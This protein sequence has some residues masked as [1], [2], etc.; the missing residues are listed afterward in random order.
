MRIKLKL[1]SVHSARVAINYNYSL[2]SAIYK[3]LRFGSPEFSAFLHHKGFIIKNK[4]YKLFTFSLQF[5]NAVLDGNSFIL[6]SPIAYLYV[7][8]PLVDEFIKSFVIGTFENQAIEIMAENIFTRFNIRQAEILPEPEFN[9]EM[10]FKMMTSTV[11]S[12]MKIVNGKL[13]PYYYR[14]NDD[15]NEINRVLM[16]NL[17]NK[18]SIIYNKEYSGKGIKLTWDENYINHALKNKKRL[19]KK[20]SILKDINKPIEIVGIYCPFNISGDKE[21]IKVGYECGF[22][23]KNSM[24]FGMAEVI[25]N[26]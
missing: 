12:T 25:A 26:N 24:G 16:Q 11:L 7:T 4:S 3:L 19:S 13:S 17:I 21:L 5:D 6:K 22:G 2:S 18:Y 14:Y 23:E 10:K 9:E 8:S 15:L 1:Y 20:V